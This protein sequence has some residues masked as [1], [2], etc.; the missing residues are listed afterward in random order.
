MDFPIHIVTISISF[1]AYRSK[2][3]NYDVFLSLKIVF[4]LANSVD[5]D[6]MLPYG[7]FH[8]G[9]HCQSTCLTVSRMKRVKCFSLKS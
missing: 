2:C 1:K 3:L 4:I 8:L 5:P 9:L 6:E 7:S